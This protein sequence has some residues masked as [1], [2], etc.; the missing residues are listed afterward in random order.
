MID[1]QRAKILLA[2]AANCEPSAVSDD[3]RIGRFDRWDSLAH[4]R[5][6]LAIEG[7][8]GRPLDPDEAVQIETLADIIALLPP[9]S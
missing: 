8:I 3:A 4:L 6:L 1:S 2:A 9:S 5:L 7:E